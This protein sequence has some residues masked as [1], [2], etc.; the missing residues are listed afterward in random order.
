MIQQNYVTVISWGRETIFP[1]T[2]SHGKIIFN[3]H[4]KPATSPFYQFSLF[5]KMGSNNPDDNGNGM[6][7][8]D[9]E[10]QIKAKLIEEIKNHPCIYNKAD[11]N[12]Y[13]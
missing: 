8:W 3:H 10:S 7:N 11:P 12:H 13:H 1:T 9:E 5:A 4:F 6:E 2:A